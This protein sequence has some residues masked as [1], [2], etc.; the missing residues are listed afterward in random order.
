MSHILEVVEVSKYFGGL[1]ALEGVTMH[2]EEGEILGLI[3]PNGA[4]KT[5][6]FNVIS[7]FLHPT[8]G[9]VR[10]RSRP[11]HRLR[12]HQVAALGV[13]RTFQIVKPFT[14]LTVR[15]NV[16]AGYGHRY[17]PTSQV[18]LQRYR[19]PQPVAEANRILSLTELM[20][21]AEQLAGSLPIGLLRR[22]EIARAL[23]MEPSLLLLDEPA[24]GLT[25]VEAEALATLVRTLRVRGITVVVI[26]HNMAFAMGLCDRI[27]VL[28]QGEVI[29]E[30]PPATV[31][32]DERV[33]N[34]YLGRV[35]GERAIRTKS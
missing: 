26:E 28:A 16:L 14:D 18:F 20:A 2:V 34:A 27:V 7:G 1:H 21:Q 23:A 19:A 10:L 13:A 24:A 25:R 8:A 3:G 29:A 35:E 9:E 17:Y 15:E 31:Q 11:I 32:T 30:G 6:L 22:L 33:I 12:P 4:G 5:T